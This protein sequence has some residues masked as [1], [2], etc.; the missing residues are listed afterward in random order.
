MLAV[1]V[2]SV[3]ER[4][5]PMYR[6]ASLPLIGFMALLGSARGE[7]PPPSLASFVDKETVAVAHIDLTKLDIK[8][9]LQRFV[10]SDAAK[11]M[12]DEGPAKIW[13]WAEAIRKAGG[14]DLDFVLRVGEVPRSLIIVLPLAAGADRAALERLL[15]GEGHVKPFRTWHEV[16][17]IR[18]ALVGGDPVDLEQLRRAD[19]KTL[20]PAWLAEAMSLGAGEVRVAL[21]P[22]AGL[23]QILDQQNAILPPVFGGGP[24]SQVFRAFKWASVRVSLEPKA[25]LHAT[26]L[27]KDPESAKDLQRR[28]A[29]IRKVFSGPRAA[30]PEI[31]KIIE[32][33]Q[34]KADGDRLTSD[35]D[36]EQ[37]VALL[38]PSIERQRLQAKRL[39]CMNNLKQIVLAMHN[40][41]AANNTFPPAF[42][43]DKDGK[44][45][46]SW[47]VLILPY[48]NEKAL[49]DEFH[50][51]ESWSSP[52][53]KALIARMPE[54]FKCLD[55]DL[56]AGRTRY[57][58][59]RGEATLFPGA[60]GIDIAQVTDGTSNT[61]AVVESAAGNSIVW[62]APNDWEVI[63]AELKPEAVLK[64]HPGG[65]NV[66]FADGSVRF[67]KGTIDAQVLN[68][69][70]T[71]AAGEVIAA[72]AF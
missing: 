21:A 56:P 67:L 47:R 42:V 9:S 41:Q 10:G 23:L 49:F 43:A 64:S 17:V 33:I 4:I 38:R 53:N 5:Q 66:A 55:A 15:K 31:V 19:P 22:N 20:P 51:D 63:P 27:A 32:M 13:N 60:E 44:P 46:L 28:E 57:L 12:S 52:H 6:F 35:F 34:V 59:P 48:L 62:T 3:P 71:R 14:T 40:Y 50:L 68:A 72:D 25:A 37:A 11:G 45:L 26:V 54:V 2:S 29:E 61:I 1:V 30:L 39:Q 70:L 65:S 7:G 69:L 18:G 36:I 16:A 8:K 24:A 58:T